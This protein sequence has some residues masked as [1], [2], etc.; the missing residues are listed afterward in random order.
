MRVPEFPT[1]LWQYRAAP[2]RT[3][4]GD[5]LVVRI[6]LGLGVHLGRGNEGAHLRLLGVDTPE[7]NEPG[8]SEARDFTMLWLAEANDRAWPLR[9]I[10]EQADSFGRY[11]A[12]VWRVSDRRCLNSDLLAAGVAVE[13]RE[14][15]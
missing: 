7:R 5:T 6:D 11:L 2:E 1:A 15:G 10:T 13:R 12:W 9:I 4:D 14:K 3:I 8:W